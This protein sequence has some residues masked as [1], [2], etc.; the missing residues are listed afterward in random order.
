MVL[1]D[2]PLMYWLHVG[3]RLQFFCLQALQTP[4]LVSQV[5]FAHVQESEIGI[6]HSAELP[7]EI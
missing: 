2:E 1:G 5:K 7:L 6:L 4:K 3:N